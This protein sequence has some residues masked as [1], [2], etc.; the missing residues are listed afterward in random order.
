MVLATA[1][2][3]VGVTVGRLE[4]DV[5][6]EAFAFSEVGVEMI[7]GLMEGSGLCVA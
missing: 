6:I 2:L 3:V 5:G 4:F 1:V 7:G